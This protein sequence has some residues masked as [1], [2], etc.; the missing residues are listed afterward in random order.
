MNRPS[1]GDDSRTKLYEKI[2]G[3]GEKSIRKSYYPLLRQKI[4]ELEKSNRELEREI[5]ER[6]Q[7]EEALRRNYENQTI[8][9]DLLKLSLD[10]IP[11]KD[12]FQVTLDKILSLSWLDNKGSASFYFVDD[13]PEYLVLKNTKTLENKSRPDCQRIPFGHC[14]CGTAANTGK[15]IFGHHDDNPSEPHGH[16]CVPI[17]LA[18]RTIGVLCIVLPLNHTYDSEEE[19]VLGAIAN[20]LAGII[21][22]N[23]MI[24][25]KTSLESQ[26]RQTQKME[27]IGAL[28]GGIAHDFNNLLT[29]ILG[30][31]EL[32][33]QELPKDSSMALDLVEVVKAAGL[34]KDLVRQILTLSRQSKHELKPLRI[35]LVVNEALKLLKSSIPSTIEIRNMVEESNRTV[36][37]DPTQIHQVIMNLCTNAYHA[38]KTKGGIMAV[39]LSHIEID[40]ENKKVDSLLLSP[41][42]YVALEVSDTGNGMTKAIQEKI[43][44]PYFTT[45]SKNEGTGLG[46][47]VV[48]GIIKN[49]G[50]HITVYSEPDQG[51]TFRV[52]LP[53]TEISR[54][55]DM[56][57]IFDPI[58]G[59]DEHI[60][61]VDDEKPIVDIT[62]AILRNH[63]Y[64]VTSC[65]G[66][67]E[68]LKVFQQSP[69]DFDLVITDMT[70]PQ[71]TG[72]Q[73]AIKLRAIRPE[74]G[75]IL[76]TGFSE[77]INEKKAESFG[78]N[79]FLMK[80]IIMRDLCHSV[81][82]V[83]D[84]AIQK[85]VNK[86]TP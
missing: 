24:E 47:S 39:R 35:H 75:M 67:L 32:A 57:K 73:L 82:G 31:T 58:P 46:L 60:L 59:G 28:A 42:D 61:V 84:K 19:D 53:C 14:L 23:Q 5:F 48:H 40:D 12:V 56:E 8:L 76:C 41:G 51:T 7:K 4:I 1:D 70:M 16:Y 86:Q 25:E 37:A 45:K 81:R 6:K 11:Q 21:Q 36:L 65:T 63:G 2:I 20:T 3:L 77:L 49:Y 34:A 74:I 13:D 71:M 54:D 15:T 18:N 44:D 9:N 68:A 69:L 22:R 38:M 79:K 64:T 26:L 29:P 85:S 33:L 30:Y 78:F 43:F 83:L 66:S 50:G 27:A 52:Y 55:S 17:R 10:A 80:P 62:S 72:A